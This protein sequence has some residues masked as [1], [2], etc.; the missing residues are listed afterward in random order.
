[1]DEQEDTVGEIGTVA[2]ITT[3]RLAA[4]G[5]G[6]RT[7]KPKPKKVKNGKATSGSRGRTPLPGDQLR[8]SQLRALAVL[9][10]CEA[11]NGGAAITLSQIAKK[12]KISQQ[13]IK[14]GLGAINPNEREGH[15]RTYGYKSL[16]SRGLIIV[17]DVEGEQRYYLSVTGQHRVSDLEDELKDIKATK[18][19]S[20]GVD[21]RTGPKAPKAGKKK[22]T[23]RPPK[24]TKAN[25][26]N[27]ETITQ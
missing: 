9:V 3:D 23:K 20:A 17:T 11:D 22:A 6:V 18:P 19:N 8:R 7:T 27:V 10:E 13:S 4:L 2:D 12:A 5:F 14:Q 24:R 25:V 16:L 15:D 21:K 26:E 1:M